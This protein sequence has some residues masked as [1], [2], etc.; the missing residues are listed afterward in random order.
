MAP[1]QVFECTGKLVAVAHHK[2]KVKLPDSVSWQG[3][4]ETPL[5]ED[6]TE[7]IPLDPMAPPPSSSSLPSKAAL[8]QVSMHPRGDSVESLQVRRGC[9]SAGGLCWWQALGPKKRGCGGQEQAS[10][11][12]RYG[13]GLA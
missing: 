8:P 4:L 10:G 5:P 12:L 2:P 7:E 1:W 9:F 3:Y 11:P 13:A 6:E